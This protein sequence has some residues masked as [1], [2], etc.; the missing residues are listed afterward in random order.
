[1]IQKSWDE[2]LIEPPKKEKWELQLY[3]LYT[4]LFLYTNTFFFP[5]KKSVKYT[6]LIDVMQFSEFNFIPGEWLVPHIWSNKSVTKVLW[7]SKII[8]SS[9]FGCLFFPLQSPCHTLAIG[10][11]QILFCQFPAKNLSFALWIKSKI[12]NILSRVLHTLYILF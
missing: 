1:M 3:E 12:L 6:K 9:F 11:I 2:F 4:V 10:V 5:L 8:I 7:S